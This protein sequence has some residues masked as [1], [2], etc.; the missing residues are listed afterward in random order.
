MVQCKVVPFAHPRV[1]ALV[2]LKRHP[3][4]L[5]HTASIFLAT[6]TAT[7]TITTTAATIATST[8]LLLLLR[9]ALP[10]TLH[11]L[12]HSEEAFAR[13]KLRNA[14]FGKPSGTVGSTQKS[15][16]ATRCPQAIQEV[17]HLNLSAGYCTSVPFFSL[18][19]AGHRDAGISLTLQ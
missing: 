11:Y 13:M 1:L 5:H 15:S 9:T 14:S 10:T 12:W 4:S 19:D 3:I 16:T 2:N 17:W 6:A 7:A 18:T 8:M